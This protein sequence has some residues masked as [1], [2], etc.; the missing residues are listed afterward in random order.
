M[1]AFGV[2][3]MEDDDD[4]D[5]YSTDN[6]SKYDRQ[7]GGPDGDRHHGWTAPSHR[8]MKDFALVVCNALAK[9]NFDQPGQINRTKCN[10]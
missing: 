6:M 7:L 4:M 10:V 1:Q 5:I 9:M 2:G 3:M 8:G